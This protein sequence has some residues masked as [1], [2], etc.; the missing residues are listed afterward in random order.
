MIFM[1]TGSI[2]TNLHMLEFVKDL[3]RRFAGTGLQFSALTTVC[4]GGYESACS[5]GTRI[6][7][8][9]INRQDS[10]RNESAC[11]AGTRI[12]TLR[13][14]DLSVQWMSPLVPLERGLRPAVAEH[15]LLQL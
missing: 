5:A 11:S 4:K 6:E 12:E 13:H 15:H 8:F 14:S 9:S 3:R 7:T 1:E 10:F 2:S